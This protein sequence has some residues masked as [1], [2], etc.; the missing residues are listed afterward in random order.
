MSP[1]KQ[2]PRIV[3]LMGLAGMVIVS[4]WAMDEA[5]N[6]TKAP[7]GTTV[8]ATKKIPP[9]DEAAAKVKTKTATFALG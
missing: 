7:E 9:L 1:T 4:A 5:G 8:I 3:S 6:S 2:W